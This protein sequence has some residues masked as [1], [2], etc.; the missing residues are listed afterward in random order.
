MRGESGKAPARRPR[1]VEEVGHDAWEASA[2][3]RWPLAGPVRRA[4]LHS[5]GERRSREAG[6]MKEK[7]D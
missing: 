6:R 5:G 7:L 4:V 1:A 3:R 2:S